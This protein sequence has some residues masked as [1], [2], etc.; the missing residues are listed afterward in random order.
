MRPTS[1]TPL[2]S[3]VPTPTLPPHGPTPAATPASSNTRRPH[4]VRAALRLTVATLALLVFCL[5]TACAA[6]PAP[7]ALAVL[8]GIF[9]TLPLCSLGEWLVHRVLYHGQ[10]PGLSI[11][12]R[13]HH[14]GHHIALFPPARYLQH[15]PYPFMNVR[16]PLLPYRMAR[17]RFEN[18]LT[19][20]SQVA[21]HFAVGVPLILLPAW[22]LS[23]RPAFLAACLG[24]LALVS[25]ALAHVHGAMHTPRHRWVERQRWFTWLDRRHYIHHVNLKANLN[26]MLPL[27]DRLFGTHRAP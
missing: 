9:F 4:A 16:A 8:A 6:R 12:R 13:I 14:H 26:F 27:C 22:W 18:W 1:T 23:P 7:A 20:S 2:R 11:L 3:P 21:L 10:V 25:F 19:E 5:V 17:T 24:T 15:G